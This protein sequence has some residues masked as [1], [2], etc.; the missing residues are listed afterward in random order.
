[1]FLSQGC[2]S[3]HTLSELG[4]IATGTVGP[5]LDEVIPGQS[6]QQVEQSIVDPNAEIAQGFA[7]GVM[8]DTYGDLPPKELQDLVEFLIES[9]G[10][11]Q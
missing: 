2:G 8:P 1:M 9:A 6:P 7:E 10:K 4:D 5:D 3:C 11:G